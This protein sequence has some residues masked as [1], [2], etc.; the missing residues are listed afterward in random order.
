MYDNAKKITQWTGG[1]L[2]A[3]TAPGPNTAVACFG[4]E[5]ATPDGFK[6]QTDTKPNDGI[7]NC[8]PKNVYKLQGDYGTGVTLA[9]VGQNIKNMK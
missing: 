8:S 4:A 2:H 5:L 9:D 7:F 1:G 3:E 6:L